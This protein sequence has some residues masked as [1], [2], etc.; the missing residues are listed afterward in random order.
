MTHE[1]CQPCQAMGAT[2]TA[3]STSPQK[4]ADARAMGATN[5]LLSTDAEVVFFFLVLLKCIYVCIDVQMCVCIYVC[6]HACI[7]ST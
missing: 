3:I 2:V 5:F 7:Q 6:L 1:P 4:E